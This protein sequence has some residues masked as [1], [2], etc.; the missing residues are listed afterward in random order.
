MKKF[1]KTIGGGDF[2]DSHCM[3]V[4]FLSGCLGFSVVV[5]GSYV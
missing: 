5:D 2:F 3:L 1:Q 4:V